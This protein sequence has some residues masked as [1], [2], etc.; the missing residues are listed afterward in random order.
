MNA[1]A[2][3]SG[4]MAPRPLLLA[5][6]VAVLLALGALALYALLAP[7]APEEGA[8]AP[9]PPE[10]AAPSGE[11]PDVAEFD[12][13]QVDPSGTVVVAGRTLPGAP[14]RLRVDGAEVAEETA[15]ARGEFVFNPADPLDPGVREL[16]LAVDTPD[17]ERVAAKTVVVSVPERG[18]A[19]VAM[20]VDEEGTPVR[21][22]QGGEAADGPLTL[23]TVT[24]GPD[25]ALTVTGRSGAEGSV[26]LYL[27]DEPVRSAR[28]GG[29]GA[30]RIDTDPVPPGT[31]ALRLDQSNLEG[32]V[33]A[34]IASTFVN[35]DPANVGAMPP[36]S[37]VV[38]VRPGQS[39][40]AIAREVYGRGL[41]YT[42]IYGSNDYQIVDPDLIY[43]G[44]LL[45]VP[46]DG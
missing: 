12:V 8:V 13:V 19:A 41:L 5:V 43:P 6:G 37:K 17:G 29:D 34:R 7:D 42:L 35:P 15:D 25:G 45:I 22:L 38:L 30:W 10:P 32:Q 28:V 4:G 33:V 1:S 46:E 3:S 21:V 24:R 9:A 18:G 16:S 2:P 36:A 40:W 23:E 11:A 27:D 31:Y 26:T 44:Q 20:L 14:V 39:L